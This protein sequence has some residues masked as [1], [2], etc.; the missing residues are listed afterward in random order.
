MIFKFTVKPGFFFFSGLL[1]LREKEELSCSK[2]M[3]VVPA[4]DGVGSTEDGHV[5]RAGVGTEQP[6]VRIT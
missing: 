3:Q 4:H 6:Y 2:F 1:R 5:A